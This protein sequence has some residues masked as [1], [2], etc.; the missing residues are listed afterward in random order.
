[1]S[2]ENR[3][4]N[5][6]AME[7]LDVQEADDVLEIGFGPG[8]GLELLL[9]TTPARTVS[10]LD[11]SAEMAEQALSRNRV[12]AEA[13]RLWV[14]VGAVE[15]MPFS[16]GQFS[17]VVAVSNFHVWRSRS[18]GLQEIRRVMRT[19]GK[20]VICLRRALDN[21]WPWSSPGLSLDTLREDQK[22]L[23]SHG[24]QDVQFATRKHRRRSC[25]L[26][27]TC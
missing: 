8:R 4:L 25:C 16:D 15:A 22:L 3:H 14:V 5:Q 27:A 18:A 17:R 10:G 7:W 21:P 13:S 11:P 20:L 9:T 19:G 23:V 12:A 1:M 2:R 26:V 6:M 24:F